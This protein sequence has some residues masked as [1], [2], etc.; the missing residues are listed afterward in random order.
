MCAAAPLPPGV[1]DAVVGGVETAL[2]SPRQ[3]L[4]VGLHEPLPPPHLVYALHAEG[5]RD[6]LIVGTITSSQLLKLSHLFLGII[7]TFSCFQTVTRL[8]LMSRS[9]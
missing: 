9:S 6:K 7:V 3:G 4:E 8:T 2:V 5:T 1:A